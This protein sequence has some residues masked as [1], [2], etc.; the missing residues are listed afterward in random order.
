MTTQELSGTRIIPLYKGG[1]ATRYAPDSIRK[2]GTLSIPNQFTP[3]V[4][5]RAPHFLP[6]T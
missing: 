3:Q 2:S 5:S 1:N 4:F 6:F